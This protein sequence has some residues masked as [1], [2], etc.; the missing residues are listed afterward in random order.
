[1]R[2]L[3]TFTL[4]LSTIALLVYFA[5]ISGDTGKL[6]TERAESGTMGSDEM[7]SFGEDVRVQVFNQQGQRISEGTFASVRQS[8]ASLAIENPDVTYTTASGRVIRIRADFLDNKTGKEQILSSKPGNRILVSEDNGI[9]IESVGPLIYDPATEILSTKAEAEFKMANFAGTCV[10]LSYRSEDFLQLESLVHFYG[11]ENADGKVDMRG[12]ALALNLKARLGTLLNGTITTQQD[13]G[14]SEFTAIETRFNFV[15]NGP[16]S[17]FT[18]TEVV[19]EGKPSRFKWKAGE[20]N[21]SRFDGRFNATGKW[22][23][24]FTTSVDAVFATTSEDE[25]S[26]KGSGGRMELVAKQWVPI[27]LSS[28]DAVLLRGRRAKGDELLLQSEG[29]LETQFVEG[30]ANSTRLF[31]APLFR[32]GPMTGKAGNLRVLHHEHKILF[33]QGAELDDPLEKVHIEGDELLLAD[34]DQVE[35]E[36]FAFKFVEINRFMGT[37]EAINAFGDQ[38]EL[39][40]PSGLLKLRGLPAKIL[41]TAETIEGNAV[42][43]TQSGAGEYDILAVD[44]VGLTLI[45]QKGTVWATAD[46]M[47]FWSSKNLIVFENVSRLALPDRGELSCGTLQAQM[48]REA[49][50]MVVDTIHAERDVVFT[51]SRLV[52]GVRRPVSC[53][54]D[55]LD[56]STSEGIIHFQGV[57][58]DVVFTD[59]TAETRNR[60]LKYNLKDGSLRGESARN[61]NSTTLVPIKRIQPKKN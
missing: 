4:T 49:G 7:E 33:T 53:Q 22:I 24:N 52:D 51:G 58:R 28:K 55:K 14:K 34:W 26:F 5:T 45:G 47:N 10:G 40:L 36:I 60:D 39:H 50:N 30:K 57:N 2:K 3:L 20:L 43:I 9:T 37:P 27:Q 12:S 31:G 35:R 32:Y 61:R 54:A 48:A 15:G 59:A 11:E 25:Y 8:D 42:E 38:L 56:Y 13:E 29:G 6:P 41:R 18:L 19:F 44:E 21:A 1:M 23:E 17:T 46:K 16:S